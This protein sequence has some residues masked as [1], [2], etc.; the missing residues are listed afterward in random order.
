MVARAAS[1][2]VRVA[3]PYWAR[4]IL[5]SALFSI[6]DGRKKNQKKGKKESTK[7]KIQKR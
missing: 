3:S 5:I 2:R 1:L 4:A 6:V 7:E